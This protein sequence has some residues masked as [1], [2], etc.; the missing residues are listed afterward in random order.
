MAGLFCKK[1]YLDTPIRDDARDTILALLGLKVKPKHNHNLHDCNV[2]ASAVADLGPIDIGK[3]RRTGQTVSPV[4][5]VD[6]FPPAQFAPELSQNSSSSN[7]AAA[8]ASTSMQAAGASSLAEAADSQVCCSQHVH[9]WKHI[10]MHIGTQ[11]AKWH[12]LACIQG[13]TAIRVWHTMTACGAFGCIHTAQTVSFMCAQLLGLGDQHAVPVYLLC[14]KAQLSCM[15][16][17]PGAVVCSP[18]Q[19]FCI[20]RLSYSTSFTSPCWL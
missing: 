17:P 3:A 9:M 5:D 7:G 14:A 12:C 4:Q 6:S 2:G 15:P 8:A 20:G 13:V 10:Q 19:T 11:G 16:L 18:N 1:G